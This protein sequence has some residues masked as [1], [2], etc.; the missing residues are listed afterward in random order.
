MNIEWGKTR[1]VSKTATNRIIELLK[2]LSQSLPIELGCTLDYNTID[3]VQL[4]CAGCYIVPER[5]AKGL[6]F[7]NDK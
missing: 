4:R 6:I 7:L 5:I 3:T 2:L 1:M